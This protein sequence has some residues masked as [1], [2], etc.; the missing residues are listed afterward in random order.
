[1]VIADNSVFTTLSFWKLHDKHLFLSPMKRRR[2]IAWILMMISMIM[3]TASVLPHHHHQEILCLQ[4]DVKVCACHCAAHDYQNSASDENHTCNAGCVTK[5][6]SVTP[7]KAQDTVS[8][9]YSFCSLLYTITDVLTLSLRLSEHNALTY[10]YYLERLHTTCLP[11]VKGLR[12][13]PYV[14]A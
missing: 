9:D 7:D 12:A 4:H 6:K 14:L 5:F 13:P 3:L 8:P 2:Y 1:M 11:H 10:N